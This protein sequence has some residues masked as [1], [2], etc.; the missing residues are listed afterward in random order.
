MA[1][2]RGIEPRHMGSKPIALPLR[3]TPINENFYAIF[4]LKRGLY[5]ILKTVNLEHHIGFE[6]MT[7]AWKAEMFPLH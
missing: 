6:P 2:A 7:S 4:H 3:Y 1:R 5:E